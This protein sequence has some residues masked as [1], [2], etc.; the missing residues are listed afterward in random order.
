[1]PISLE[2]LILN[3]LRVVLT[4][5]MK[6]NDKNSEK[7]VSKIKEMADK[8]ITFHDR[9]QLNNEADNTFMTVAVFIYGFVGVIALI[10]ILNIVNT[11]NTSVVAK[12]KYLG[13]MRAI[14]MTG[15][16]LNKMVLAQ[17]ITYSLSGC[18]FGSILGILIQKKL[19]DILASDWTFPI[20]QVIFIFIIS[21]ITPVF[22]VISPLKRIM[23]MSLLAETYSKSRYCTVINKVSGGLNM[24]NFTVEELCEAH[25]ALR[26]TLHKCE[27]MDA[28]KLG[29]SQHTLLERRIAARKVA[30]TLIEKEQSQKE[31]GEK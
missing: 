30:L 7:T 27:K 15:K 10:R 3:L 23:A 5:D 2:T 31:Q 22:S 9:R 28:S 12:T 16:Q 11:M 26:S 1:M 8:S 24:Q 29:K 21:I 17:S 18:I 4:V 6:L 14:D 19:L 25:R 13:T 20:R